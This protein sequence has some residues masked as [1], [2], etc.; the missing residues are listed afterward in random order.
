MVESKAPKGKVKVVGA[1][2]RGESRKTAVYAK[3][4]VEDEDGKRWYYGTSS[5]LFDLKP[6]S[7]SVKEE[8]EDE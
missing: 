4:L 5:F 8:K 6:Y 7:E 3:V 1:E 2:Q